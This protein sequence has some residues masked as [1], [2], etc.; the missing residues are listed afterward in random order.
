MNTDRIVFREV[1]KFYGEVL[2]VNRVHLDLE[3]GMIGLVA[4]VPGAILTVTVVDALDRY[5]HPAA[6]NLR[7]DNLRFPFPY[8]FV[9][10]IIHLH[11]RHR[12]GGRSGSA[13]RRAL[14]FP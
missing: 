11:D 5:Q 10:I 2:G 14:R 7:S 6:H 9:Q 4:C 12:R 3:P 1:S 8:S 13:I